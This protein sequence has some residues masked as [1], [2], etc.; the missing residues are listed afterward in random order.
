MSYTWPI[1]NLLSHLPL[2]VYVSSERNSATEKFSLNARI[3]PE[4]IVEGPISENVKTLRFYLFTQGSDQENSTTTNRYTFEVSQCSGEFYKVLIV[5]LM[6]VPEVYEGNEFCRL[7]RD[8]NRSIQIPGP[9]T[10]RPALL[11][12]QSLS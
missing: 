4:L 6:N 11:E 10:S 7:I 9:S 12:R 1:I 2:D 5:F 8:S 3:R